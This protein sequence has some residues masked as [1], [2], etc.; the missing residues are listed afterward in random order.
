MSTDIKNILCVGF[1]AWEGNYLKST[2]LLIKGLSRIHTVLYVEY[3]FTI[4]DV[5]LGI[6]R[7]RKVPVLRIVR[8]RKWLRKIFI[9]NANY[10][11]VLTLPPM[12]PVNWIRSVKMYEKRMKINAAVSNSTAV[13]SFQID[14]NYFFPR[15]IPE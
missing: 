11:Y 4:K 6:L 9:D 13:V 7:R 8:I 12:L 2:I 15:L 1:P 10:L 5:I 14:Q 3:T